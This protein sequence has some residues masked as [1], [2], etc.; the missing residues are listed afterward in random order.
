VRQ[1]ASSAAGRGA[2]GM[3]NKGLGVGGV[4][5]AGVGVEL[6]GLLTPNWYVSAKLAKSQ[7]LLW[8]SKKGKIQY[9]QYILGFRLKRKRAHTTS[10]LLHMYGR[11]R[12]K[13]ISVFSAYSS[14][15]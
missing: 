4:V 6:L 15:Y 12:G 10:F 9:I 7:L 8:Y 11:L 5:T 14:T 1:K 3:G 2:S 13:S